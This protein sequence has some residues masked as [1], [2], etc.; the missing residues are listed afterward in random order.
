MNIDAYFDQFFR[1]KDDFIRDARAHKVNADSLLD[2]MKDHLTAEEYADTSA[3]GFTS[4]EEEFAFF[5]KANH[6]FRKSQIVQSF[7]TT[8]RR[9]GCTLTGEDRKA[10]INALGD[11]LRP[12]EF[13]GADADHARP[14]Q[15]NGQKTGH[16]AASSPER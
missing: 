9:T 10:F 5:R 13:S 1:I 2:W 15:P 14:R 8:L 11:A 4:R 3:L 16:R 6:H 12:E 7:L